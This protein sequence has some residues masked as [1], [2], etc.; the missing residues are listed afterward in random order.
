MPALGRNR[1]NNGHPATF[2]GSHILLQRGENDNRRID[3]DTD[4]ADDANDSHHAQRILEH[5]Q[6]QQTQAHGQD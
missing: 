6:H 1:L 4:G 2:S 5:G 3:G